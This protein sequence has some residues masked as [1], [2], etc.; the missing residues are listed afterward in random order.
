[1]NLRPKLSKQKLTENEPNNSVKNS[2]LSTWHSRSTSKNIYTEI[3]TE[4]PIENKNNEEFQN[5]IEVLNKEIES[6]IK[7]HFVIS[8]IPTR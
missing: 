5:E 1:M 8:R 3:P 4:N 6:L 7:L 2:K